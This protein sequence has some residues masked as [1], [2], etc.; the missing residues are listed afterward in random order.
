M[1]DPA[2]ALRAVSLLRASL[3]NESPESF[4]FDGIFVWCEQ[5]I[6]NGDFAGPGRRLGTLRNAWQN[7]E[8]VRAGASASR[9]TR[10]LS[11]VPSAR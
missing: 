11:M 8:Q 3:D 6:S 2:A 10:M 9:P 4:G 5:A 1:A 7:A